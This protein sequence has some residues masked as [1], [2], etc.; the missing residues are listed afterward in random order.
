MIQQSTES[1]FLQP[2]QSEAPCIPFELQNFKC[3]VILDAA[4]IVEN[5]LSNVDFFAETFGVVLNKIGQ[6]YEM[7]EL[8]HGDLEKIRSRILL[9][10]RLFEGT[11]C[12]ESVYMHCYPNL[13]QIHIERNVRVFS[14]Y[15]SAVPCQYL[16]QISVS[17]D[18]QDE[19]HVR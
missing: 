11:H 10:V 1:Q 8:S 17:V 16:T 5:L 6:H 4:R 9:P 7:A 15:R 14:Y 12:K 3:S 13:R 18:R 19:L 2:L